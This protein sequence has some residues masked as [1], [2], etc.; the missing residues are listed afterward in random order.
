MIPSS[1]TAIRA[2]TFMCCSGFISLDIPDSVT[3]INES[4]V[5]SCDLLEQVVAPAHLHYLFPDIASVT[6]STQYLLK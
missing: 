6:E 4:A 2:R 3:Q 5:Y 1:V